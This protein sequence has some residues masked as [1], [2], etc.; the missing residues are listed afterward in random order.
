MNS[1]P[2]TSN[3]A[4][5]GH[6]RPAT[7][8]VP[9][10]PRGRL[11]VRRTATRL[12]PTP[13][14]HPVIRTRSFRQHRTDRR[15]ECF[16]GARPLPGRGVAAGG[17]Q[18]RRAAR[19]PG[20]GGRGEHGLPREHAWRRGGLALKYTQPSQPISA[21]SAGDAPDDTF[22]CVRGFP[23]RSDYTSHQLV[24]RYAL[25]I[26]PPVRQGGQYADPNSTRIRP[27]QFV[28]R[29]TWPLNCGN[30]ERQTSRAVRRVLS[31]NRL[32]AAGETAIHL[33]PA[34]PPVSCGL[35]GD[36]G[37]QPSNVPAGPPLQ[38]PLL[39]LLRVGFT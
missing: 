13:G 33:G 10:P 6:R 2:A 1:C 39:T 38:R 18:F 19:R 24:A 32:A 7:G 20:S 35:P 12:A 4:G 29:E 5:H 22:G 27:G 9:L 8:P 14:V 15:D 16:G 31:P 36:S 17:P 23:T 25:S 3:A 37:G 21:R 30:V 34:L 28:Q 26:H 11:L